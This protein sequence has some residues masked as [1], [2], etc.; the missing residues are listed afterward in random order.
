MEDTL[1]I[2]SPQH[3]EASRSAHGL[4]LS[5]F[6][7]GLASKAMHT[8]HVPR[9]PRLCLCVPAVAQPR[10][11]HA[12]V[13]QRETSAPHQG[14]RRQNHRGANDAAVRSRRPC[15][16]PRARARSIGPSAGRL[17]CA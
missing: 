5:W 6:R 1:A 17:A 3:Q 2:A 11:R 16:R 7:C 8:R 12:R 13:G 14:G 10:R 15:A 4:R 9:S